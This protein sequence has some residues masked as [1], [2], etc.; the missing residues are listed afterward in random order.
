MTQNKTKTGNAD[1]TICFFLSTLNVYQMIVR[2]VFIV[3][4]SG[5]L[6]RALDLRPFCLLLT[7]RSY[8]NPIT[9]IFGGTLLIFA[10]WLAFIQFLNCSLPDQCL[11]LNWFALA[12]A[13]LRSSKMFLKMSSFFLVIIVAA[14]VLRECCANGESMKKLYQVTWFY[15][16]L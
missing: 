15:I 9:D 11:Q 13:P 12:V 4:S 1:S 14:T 5:E 7:S 16:Q 6:K 3:I 8:V 10:Y 2:D